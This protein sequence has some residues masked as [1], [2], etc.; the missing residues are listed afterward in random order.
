M[1]ERANGPHSGSPEGPSAA[2]FPKHARL[3]NGAEYGRV[4]ARPRVCRDRNF[5]VLARANGLPHAR[6]GLAVSKKICK[7]AV[8]R[9]RLKRLVRESFRRHRMQLGR[10]GGLDLVVLPARQAASICNR[11]LD[12]SLAA[13]WRKLIESGQREAGK[14]G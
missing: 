3:T 1:S 4:F 13:L 2:T 11:E 8:G 10:K 5:R 6:L 12:E 14:Q 9:N 7:T